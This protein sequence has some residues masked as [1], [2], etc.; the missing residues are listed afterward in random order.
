MSSAAHR[1]ALVLACLACVGH[2]RRIQPE[3]IEPRRSQSAESHKLIRK[4][5]AQLLARVRS[6]AAFTPSGPGM[7]VGV[8]RPL[9]ANSHQLVIDTRW[10][11]LERD[12]P[13]H[14]L[15]APAIRMDRSYQEVTYE[16]MRGLPTQSLDSLVKLLE[17]KAASGE[18]PV[19]VN[20]LLAVGNTIFEE[21]DLAE[22][23]AQKAID[24]GGDDAEMHFVL[25]Y[26]GECAGNVN[27]ALEE[28]DKCMEMDETHW[29]AHY[30][31]GKLA[32]LFNA[33]AEAWDLMSEVLNIK[34]DHAPTIQLFENLKSKG[35]TSGEELAK[36]I[37]EG[38][39]NVSY[40]PEGPPPGD[41]D[42]E[43]K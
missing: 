36:A 9:P 32:L 18:D 16:E 27:V 22:V 11:R 21:T 38:A 4:A 23:N 20:Q 3:I 12:V 37:D 6:T 26:A 41:D 1:I 35:I 42:D 40:G 34:P 33:G 19:K 7:R 43:D 17:R 13:H 29:R 31:A 10:N 24:A 30:Q 15:R 8:A 28:Y 5:M 39:V 2:G 14:G 25:G